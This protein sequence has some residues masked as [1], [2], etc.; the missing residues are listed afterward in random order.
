MRALYFRTT[1][2]LRFL[3]A[4]VRRLPE[5]WRENNFL[6]DSFLPAELMPGIRD[7]NKA[8]CLDTGE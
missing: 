3:P 5:N 4:G 7:S 8:F 2:T 1:A 6:T